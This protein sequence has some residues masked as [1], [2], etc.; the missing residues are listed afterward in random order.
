MSFNQYC[1]KFVLFQITSTQKSEHVGR[2][3][4][5][6]IPWN[7]SSVWSSLLAE[8]LF[9]KTPSRGVDVI[10]VNTSFSSETYNRK[11]KIHCNKY[12]SAILQ[13]NI[14]H[15]IYP[16]GHSLLLLFWY[17]N[18]TPYRAYQLFQQPKTTS[19]ILGKAQSSVLPIGGDWSIDQAGQSPGIQH[20]LLKWWQLMRSWDRCFSKSLYT[21]QGCQK[22]V[23][24]HPKFFTK[25]F[26]PRFLCPLLNCSVKI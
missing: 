5:S 4:R 2:Q 24:Y 23:E 11:E 9:E 3:N 26:V 17:L 10:D 22:D 25:T 21:S 19:T 12:C 14:A 1:S 15:L 6:L 13:E 8:I 16:P 18:H 7:T 20:D